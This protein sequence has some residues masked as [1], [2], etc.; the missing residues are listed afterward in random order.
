MQQT[1]LS[2]WIFHRGFISTW[3]VAWNESVVTHGFNIH[4][5][6][7]WEPTTFIFRG[8]NPYVGGVKPSFFM[9][10]GSHGMKIS[11]AQ[12]PCATCATHRHEA[13]EFP[14]V[15]LHGEE[16]QPLPRPKR[17]RA[18]ISTGVKGVH[19]LEATQLRSLWIFPHVCF[20]FPARWWMTVEG[21]YKWHLR[22]GIV[23]C[24]GL[25]GKKKCWELWKQIPTEHLY[26]FN[27]F[28]GSIRAKRWYAE[29]VLHQT[30]SDVFPLVLDLFHQKRC[31]YDY[32]V[33]LWLSAKSQKVFRALSEYVWFD[34]PSFYLLVFSYLVRISKD[35]N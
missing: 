9:V 22:H 5:R 8:Y 21:C 29:H 4:V 28:L 16:M 13:A 7:P 10:L 15:F 19:G 14:P 26:H 11:K 3:L 2:L 23:S 27:S 33:A 1:P 25:L 18:R 32:P 30:N 31:K 34:L 6:P 12:L 35:T 17:W 24:W 20:F